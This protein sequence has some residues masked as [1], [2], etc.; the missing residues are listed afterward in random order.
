MFYSQ[1][2]EDANADLFALGFDGKDWDYLSYKIVRMYQVLERVGVLQTW[3]AD[4]SRAL[5]GE[6]QK[7]LS[8]I[9]AKFAQK[10]AKQVVTENQKSN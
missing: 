7:D 10:K 3:L 8:I 2:K 6:M 1:I 9:Y 5:S 4:L